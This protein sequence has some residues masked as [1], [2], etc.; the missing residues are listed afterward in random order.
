MSR[1]VVIVALE[2]A[3]AS[4]AAEKRHG[5]EEDEDE[6][7]LEVVVVVVVVVIEYEHAA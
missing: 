6:A 1:F 4:W 2:I 7:V 3:P 5:L